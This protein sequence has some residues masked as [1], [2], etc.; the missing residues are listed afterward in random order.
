MAQIDSKCVGVVQF[1]RT[2][3]TLLDADGAADAGA[4]NKYV[5][6]QSVT[7]AI[8]ADIQAATRRTVT[9]GCGCVLATD[10]G[11]ATLLG[12]NL[13]LVSGTWEPAMQSLM[14]GATPIYD[15][16]DTPVIIGVNEQGGD[17]LGCGEDPRE[18]A[19]EAWAHAWDGAG[20]DADLAWVH[21][22][23]PRTRWSRSPETIGEEFAQPGLSG[24]VFQNGGWLSGPYDDV[25][26]DGTTP[27]EIDFYA[28]F[29]TS[30]EPPTATCALQTVS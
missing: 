19:F 28:K 18:V 3:V 21:F 17:I 10:A 13:E 25:P 6:D 4:G 7:L 1:C 26:N 15:S 12:Y 14:L 5:S 9:S 23:W 24:L 11:R 2:R 30:T 8:N 16:S 27:I 20:P 22:V 29:L